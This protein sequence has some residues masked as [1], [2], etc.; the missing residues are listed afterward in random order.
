MLNAVPE[1]TSGSVAKQRGA[2]PNMTNVETSANDLYE[3][4][5]VVDFNHGVESPVLG[6]AQ[7]MTELR[8]L[9]P[10]LRS[11][12][13]QG[14]WVL[15]DGEMIREMLADPKTFSSS[16]TVPT[17]PDP[18]Y[19]WIPQMLDPPE[20]TAWRRLLAPYFSPGNLAKLD[21]S[22]QSR[23]NDL[24]NE[25][26]KQ[27]GCEYRRDFADRYPTSIFLDMFGA[28]IDELQMFLTWEKQVLHAT[29]EEDPDGSRQISA[30]MEVM[31]YFSEL[32]E[33]R[34]KDPRDDIV[35]HSLTWEIDDKPIPTEQLLSFC[36]LMFLAGLDT[37]SIQL[38]YSTWHLATHPEDRRQIVENP[39]IIRT[40]VE[41][42]LRLYS[43]VPPG[44]KVARDIEF[45]GVPMKKGDMV[46]ATV[47]SPSHDPRS[48]PDPMRAQLDRQP[49]PH[50]AFGL[51]PHRCVGAALA[52]RELVIAME[53]WHRRIPNYR[54]KDGFVPLERGSMHGIKELELEFT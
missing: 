40:A 17:I 5:P 42:L 39:D 20:H 54:I 34:R 11:S 23:C 7:R 12:A 19:L 52:R 1:V 15:T 6:H 43:F 3:G 24:L 13:A 10:I 4:V 33:K 30:M 29:P 49:N 9:G 48:Y 21:A 37:V 8:K 32:I 45:H 26:V 22:V 16:A 35:S 28:P 27:G 44:R 50:P 53:Q 31:G 18:P 47:S 36:L 51:G 41:E 14:F 38:T 46:F 2:P 25:V